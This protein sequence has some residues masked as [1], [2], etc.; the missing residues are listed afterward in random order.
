MGKKVF[1]IPVH[2]GKGDISNCGKFRGIRLLDQAVKVLRRK[3][4]KHSWNGLSTVWFQCAKINHRGNIDA[5]I[6]RKVHPKQLEVIPYICVV[7]RPL[8]AR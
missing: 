8:I 4:E 7:R 2:K 5:T 6:T 3:I 1:T